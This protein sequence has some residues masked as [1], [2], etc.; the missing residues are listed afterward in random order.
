MLG[1]EKSGM[2]SQNYPEIR[3]GGVKEAMASGAGLERAA[4]AGA[5]E[6]AMS[7]TGSEVGREDS[8]LGGRRKTGEVMLFV[9][10]LVFQKS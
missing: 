1:N 8:F 4:V 7:S 5:R 9:G 6:K 10:W 2:R 3:K